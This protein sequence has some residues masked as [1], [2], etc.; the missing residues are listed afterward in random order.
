MNVIV[1]ILTGFL[2]KLNYAVAAI[3]RRGGRQGAT[4]VQRVGKG[5][6]NSDLDSSDNPNGVI[7]GEV[8]IPRLS[9]SSLSWLSDSSL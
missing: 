4:K 1:H 9:P 3:K 2:V 6:L 7:G 5:K 8:L